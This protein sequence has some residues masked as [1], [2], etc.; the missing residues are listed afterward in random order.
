[1]AQEENQKIEIPFGAKDSELCGWEY[2]IP[3]GMEAE[4]KGGKIVVRKK[5]IEDKKNYIQGI[6][7]TLASIEDKAHNILGLYDYDW[8]AIRASHRLLGEYLDCLENQKEQNPAEW[9]EEDE[10]KLNGITAIVEE[11]WDNQ[12]QKEKDYYGDQGYFSWLKSL[13]QKPKVAIVNGQIWKPTEEQMAALKEASVSW[14]N[15][16]MGNADLLES[17]YN[18][19]KKL[20]L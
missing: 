20:H 5:E 15:D 18:D 19:L 16:T 17:L 2:T 7:K 9:S 12:S 13:H 14:M 1:M 11:W 3:E 8:V 6:R 4:I 10:K